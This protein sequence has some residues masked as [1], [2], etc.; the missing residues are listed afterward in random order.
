MFRDTV[1]A[2]FG[3]EGLQ[4]TDVQAGLD[5]DPIPAN[6]EDPV[7]VALAS[8]CSELPAGGEASPG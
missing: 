4:V 3:V 8:R 7:M 5:G 1:S 6:F 2:L